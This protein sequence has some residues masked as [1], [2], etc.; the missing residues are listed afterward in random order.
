[1]EKKNSIDASIGQKIRQLRNEHRVTQEKL[2]EVLGVSFQ[3]VQKY[4]RGVNRISAG[5]LYHIA[6]LFSVP[7]SHFFRPEEGFREEHPAP[8]PS[9]ETRDESLMRE[10]GSSPAESAAK[11]RISSAEADEVLVAYCAIDNR[12][13]RAQL[14]ALLKSLATLDNGPG[15]AG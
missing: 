1:M 9:A 4:E 7:V 2:G 8:E 5:K 14:R 11:S 10:G 12:E 3:Q 13:L 15:S 6:R